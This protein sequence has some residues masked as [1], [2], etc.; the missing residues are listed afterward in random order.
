MIPRR[1]VLIR[2]VES[3]LAINVEADTDAEA[4]RIAID[5]CPDSSR[6]WT[7][8]NREVSASVEAGE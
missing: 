1:V 3:E 2:S 7:E 5:L 8:V 4:K 6:E